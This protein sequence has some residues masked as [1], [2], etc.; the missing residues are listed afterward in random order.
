MLPV[1][2]GNVTKMLR[3]VFAKKCREFGNLRQAEY[4]IQQL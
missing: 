2:Y 4:F 1:N 3:V